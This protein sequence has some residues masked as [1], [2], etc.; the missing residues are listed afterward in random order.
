MS[1]VQVSVLPGLSTRTVSQHPP[2]ATTPNLVDLRGTDPT[3]R[4]PAM[5]D[6]DTID[7]ELRLSRNY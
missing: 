7:S 1:I 6:L 2:Q 3:R 5:R 4:L